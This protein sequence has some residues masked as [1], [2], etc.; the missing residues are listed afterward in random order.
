MDWR[1]SC[2]VTPKVFLAVLSGMLHTL[3][4]CL[5]VTPLGVS[6]RV[7]KSSKCCCPTSSWVTSCYIVIGHFDQSIKKEMAELVRGIS[8]QTESHPDGLN[9]GATPYAIY[10]SLTSHEQVNVNIKWYARLWRILPIKPSWDLLSIE[11]GSVSDFNTFSCGHKTWIIVS[12]ILSICA[13]LLSVYVA[14][15]CCGA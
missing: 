8:G 5:A 11:C 6:A 10:K 14:I 2:E 4:R 15:V 9:A 12:R 13:N 1:L 3:L 7:A